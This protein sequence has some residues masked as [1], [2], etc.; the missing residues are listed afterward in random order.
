[1]ESRYNFFQ[2]GLNT[3]EGNNLILFVMSQHNWNELKVEELRNELKK[4]GLKSGGTKS[5]LVSR[6]M[7]SETPSKATS[8]SNSSESKSFAPR[9]HVLFYFQSATFAFDQHLLP[10]SRTTCSFFIVISLFF[11]KFVC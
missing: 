11:L 1:V 9:R 8:K 6:L 7:S 2:F 3:L 5:E 10:S 4:R